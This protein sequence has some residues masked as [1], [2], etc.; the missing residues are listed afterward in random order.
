[1]AKL[2]NEFTRFNDIIKLG[3]YDENADLRD[4]RD[5][6]V[7]ELKEALK[8]EVVPD[9][10]RALTF[11]KL[12]QGS[13]AMNTG[14]KP[15]NSDYDID[16]GINFDLTNDEYD[17]NK[18]KKLVFDTLNKKHNRTVEFNRPCITVRYADGYHVDLVIYANNNGDMHIAWGKQHSVENRCWYKADPK[19]LIKWVADVSRE[20]EKRAQLRRCVRMLKKWKEDKFADNGNAAPPSIGLTIQARNAFIY[21]AESDL[22]VL[23]NIADAIIA[24]FTHQRE[25][26]LDDWK[27][28]TETLLPVQPKKDV[29][30]KMTLSQL[31]NF[32]HRTVDLVEALKATKE[33][34][35]D[36]LASKIL[37]KVFGGD[38]PLV[39]DSKK[40]AAAPYVVTGLNA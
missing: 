40:T 29:Y 27:W 18:L 10:D 36:H 22:D 12:D 19:G 3:T 16:V 8:D 28:S 33:E 6:L 9:T 37:R 21:K 38:F 23:I 1:M 20:E 5:L 4:K 17:S 39:E 26:D 25:K 34:D 14:I 2:Q 7:A 13:Y 35:S 15:I 24:G 32:Y 11:T 31:D 30:Y